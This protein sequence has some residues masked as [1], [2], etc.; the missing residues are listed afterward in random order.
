MEKIIRNQK[1]K[2]ILEVLVVD[3]NYA[4]SIASDIRKVFNEEVK[5]DEADTVKKA[6]ELCRTRNYY[7]ILLDYN[8]D[9]NYELGGYNKGERVALDIRKIFPKANI[10]GLSS[11]WN[12][13]LASSAGLNGYGSSKNDAIKYIKSL[14]TEKEGDNK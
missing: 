14:L 2:T 13:E 9:F 8:L 5:I 4:W 10:F 3:D 11:S 6:I 12:D 1:G 7:L